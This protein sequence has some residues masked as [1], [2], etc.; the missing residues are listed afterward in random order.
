M[1][2]KKEGKV[3]ALYR[4]WSNRSHCW[5]IRSIALVVLGQDGC[6]YPRREP[7]LFVSEASPIEKE[8]GERATEEE[9]VSGRIFTKI[10][11]SRNGRYPAAGA[12]ADNQQKAKSVLA[13]ALGATAMIALLLYANPAA[14]EAVAGR[15]M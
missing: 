8:T 9:R 1:F 15:I 10:Y 4:T 11:R 5:E 12:Y 14:A 6:N 2:L 3:G 7:C 13:V